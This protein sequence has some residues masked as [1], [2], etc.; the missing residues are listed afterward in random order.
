MVACNS[1]HKMEIGKDHSDVRARWNIGLLASEMK[2]QERY[3]KLPDFLRQSV[4]MIFL[5]VKNDDSWC[6]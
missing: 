6:L 5:I 3:I 1:A 4:E 2:W